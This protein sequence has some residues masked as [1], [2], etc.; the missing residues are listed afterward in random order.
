[1]HGSLGL[2]SDDVSPLG[3]FPSNPN[4]QEKDPRESE[5][6]TQALSMALLTACLSVKII[7]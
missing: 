3:Y 7:L 4:S 5:S 2:Q 1:M 6:I